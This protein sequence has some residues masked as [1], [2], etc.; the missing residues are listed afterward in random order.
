MSAYLLIPLVQTFFCLV[1]LGIVLKGNLHKPTHRLFALFLFGLAIWGVAIYGMRS[2]QS[3]ER[4]LFWEK[5][6]PTLAML[7]S[8]IFYH[9]AIRY[10]DIRVKGWLIPALYLFCV[11]YTPL[12]ATDLLFKGMQLKSY[13][14][15]PIFGPVA[16]VHIVFAYVLPIMALVTFI[17]SYKTS[18]SAEDRNSIAY[19]VTGTIIMFVGGLFDILPVF[20]LPLYPGFIIGNIVF[21]LLT[22]VAILKHKLFDISIVLRRGV[23]YMLISTL[24]AIPFV[25]VFL[26]S[27][28]VFKSVSPPMWA[29]FILLLLLALVLPLLWQVVQKWVDRWFYRDRYDYLKALETFSRET[30]S[31]ENSTELVS[32]IV[33]LVA[34][35]LR[36]SNVYLLQPLSPTGDFTVVFSN[37]INAAILP[38][39]S[40]GALINWLKRSSKSL[41]YKDLSIIPQLQSISSREIEA[42]EGMGA[43]IISPIQSHTGQLAGL[44]ILGP[45]ISGQPYTLEDYQLISTVSSQ[46]AVKLENI[47]LYN[48]ALQARQQ[49]ETWLDSM[50]DCVMIANSD[51]TVQFL[52]KVAVERFGSEIDKMCWEKLKRDKKCKSCPMRRYLDGRWE[53]SEHIRTIDDRQYDVAITPISDVDSNLSVIEVLRDVTEKKRME[54][55]IIEARA[56]IEALHHSEKMK[57][58]LLSMVSHELRSPLTVIKGFTTTLLRSHIRRDIKKQTEYLRAIDQASDRMTR[59]VGHLLDLSYL[60]SGGF[61]LEKGTYHISEIIESIHAVLADIHTNHE[62]E[63]SISDDIP[64]VQAD[65]MRI[66]QVLTNL[67]ENAAKHSEKGTRIRIAARF[68]D[69]QVIV[70]V[71]DYGKGIPSESLN[72]VF[73]RFYRIKE[74]DKQTAGLGLGLAICKAI[75]EKHGGRIWVESE[76]GKGSTFSFS[77]PISTVQANKKQDGL[78]HQHD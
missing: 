54:D 55:E 6:L 9:F 29:Y 23:T 62:F 38:V 34:G 20:S 45:K 30:Q 39:N 15:A 26:L 43:E 5:C 11:V 13:G 59:M 44:L 1:L 12:V 47:R 75:I 48:D 51:Y 65:A 24:M 49:L 41:L 73:D 52:N 72:K 71:T 27:T 42:L 10:N 76:V 25:G 31:I 57:T 8:V 40:R 64:P 16:P 4:A 32:N 36:V 28:H 50:N 46:I 66:G 21:C 18:T 77:L 60:E 22:A 68:S 35:A 74:N 19:I 78:I 69:D 2:S 70:M 56:R 7:S 63:I 33:N 61:V 37:S 67:I 14:Y 58:E 3:L 17:R 53:I